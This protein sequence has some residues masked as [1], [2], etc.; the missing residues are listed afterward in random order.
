MKTRTE[1]WARYRADIRKTPENKFPRRKEIIE[2][3]SANDEIVIAKSTSAKGTISTSGTKKT[4]GTSYS[5]YTKRKR[6]QLIIKLAVTVV[7]IV[8]F[9]LAWFLWVRG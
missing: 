4:R 2:D 1:K 9:V 5:V 8:A 7:V 6:A 3:T